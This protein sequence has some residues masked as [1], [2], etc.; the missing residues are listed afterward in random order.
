MDTEI[1]ATFTNIDTGDVRDRL[2]EIGAKQISK[3]R[4][5]RR[6]NYDYAD[7][8]LQ[9]IGGWVRLRDEGDKVTL[10]YKQL[11][12]RTLHGMKEVSFTVED[13]EKPALFLTSIGFVQ[14]SY[15]ET[16]RE[17]WMIDGV[18]VEIDEWPWIPPFIEIEGK[19]EEVVQLV[20]ERL[21]FEWINAQ[22]GSVETIYQENYNVTEEEVD[23][24]DTITFSEA[25]E[26]L[27]RKRK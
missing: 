2:V 17:S 4:I 10:S 16:K 25:P 22:H 6:K 5:L 7:N 18:E 8:R 13:F 19:S 12:D 24:W 3:E 14:K 27:E 9:K 1:E 23:N 21:G 15:Q 11:N 26:W 20:A